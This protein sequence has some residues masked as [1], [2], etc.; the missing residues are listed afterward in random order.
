MSGN[1]KNNELNPNQKRAI[2]ALL[3]HGSV[4]AAAETLGLSEKTLYRY[5]ENETFKRALNF[6]VKGLIDSA[7]VR[8]AAGQ[9]GALDTLETIMYNARR[10]SDRRLAAVN[11]LTFAVKWR[12][13]E[14]VEGRLARLEELVF[15]GRDE[16]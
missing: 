8:L 15:G 3:T 6:A 11:W 5:L 14:N 10:D 2:P 4:A 16:R 12:E 9:D 1:D 7:G 13:L